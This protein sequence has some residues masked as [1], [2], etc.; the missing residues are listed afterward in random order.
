MNDK[1]TA[2]FPL[3]GGDYTFDGVALTRDP[4]PVSDADA[5]PDTDSPDGAVNDSADAPIAS[6]RK[7][8]STG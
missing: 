1:P 4:G 7:P 5:A 2:P 6:R 8:R 3:S